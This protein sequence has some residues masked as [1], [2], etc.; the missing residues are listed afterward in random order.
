MDL[1]LYIKRFHYIQTFQSYVLSV[2]YNDF[3]FL[4]RVGSPFKHGNTTRKALA[5]V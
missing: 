2:L 3:F 5:N 4:L 1:V